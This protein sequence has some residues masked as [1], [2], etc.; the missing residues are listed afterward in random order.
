MLVKEATAIVGGISTS[1]AK[2]TCPVMGLPVSTCTQ[3]YPDNPRSTCHRKNCY[4]KRNLYR[5]P[6]V[7][8]ALQRRLTAA[9]T[10]GVPLYIEAVRT[11]VRRKQL[12]RFFDSG[13][14]ID[15]QHMEMLLQATGNLDTKIW[16]PTKRY[17]LVERLNQQDIFTTAAPEPKQV[18]ENICIRVGA[19]Q[20][21]PTDDTMNA[22]IDTYGPCAF[23]FKHRDPKEV[24]LDED[25][26]ICAAPKHATCGV[27]CIACWLNEEKA[28]IYP[29]H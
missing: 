17:D 24:L 15:A 28:V 20:I 18:A 29:W 9:K 5:T 19:W 10:T 13:D 21:D 3:H 23:V 14:F 27:D 25:P 2:M 16:F 1:N 11:L 4:A 22:Y 7:R 12:W 26:I 8:G 6:A